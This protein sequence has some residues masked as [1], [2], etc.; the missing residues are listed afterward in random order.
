MGVN[1]LGCFGSVVLPLNQAMKTH[2]KTLTASTPEELDRLV[3]EYVNNRWWL[4]GGIAIGEERL[5][6]GGPVRLVYAQ[7]VITTK[8]DV[9]AEMM[10]AK[11]EVE[12]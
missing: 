2:Y 3:Y 9:P 11:V 7:A 12:A 10:G 1:H 6:K 8:G 4:Q 5:F